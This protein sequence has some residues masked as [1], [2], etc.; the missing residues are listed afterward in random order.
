[1]EG[2]RLKQNQLQYQQQSA[3]NHD[4]SSSDAAEKSKS[5]SKPN[6]DNSNP[7]GD[8][9]VSVV[10]PFQDFLLTSHGMVKAQRTLDGGIKLQHLGLTLMDGKDGPFTFDI[11]KIRLVNFNAEDGVIVNDYDIDDDYHHE[12]EDYHPH[13]DDEENE[14]RHRHHDHHRHYDDM[15]DFDKE[16]HMDNREHYDEYD[17]DILQ[18][19]DDLNLD[20]AQEHG[21]KDTSKHHKQ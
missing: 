5:K 9:F 2:R 19:D 14:G 21:T 4:D 8:G 17:D 7:D 10:L 3:T 15:D 11:S 16:D 1:M 6:S 13:H 20:E 18:D 12:E